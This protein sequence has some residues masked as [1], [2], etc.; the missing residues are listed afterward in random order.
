MLA[1]YA[2]ALIIALAVFLRL[3][4]ILALR[5]TPWFEHLVVD[6]AYYDAWARQ[7]AAGDWFG[8]RPFYMDPLY[9]YLLGV[10]YAVCGH[11]LLAA[12]LVNV[13]LSAIACGALA[14]IGTRV[15]GRYAG[16]IAALGFA[17][18]EPEIFYA[19]EID[20]TTLSVMLTSVALALGLD[21]RRGARVA[22][23]AALGLATLTRA[24]F[25][26]LAPLAAVAIGLDGGRRAPTP[27]GRRAAWLTAVGFLLGFALPL[28]P[29]MWRNHAVGGDWVVT[30]QAGQNFYTGNNALNPYGA[31]GALPFV[32]GNPEFEETD[33]RAEAER[34][35]GHALSPSEVSRFW[36]AA[37]IDHMANDPGFATHALARKLAL[38]W[39]DF[40]IADNQDQYLLEHDSWV[41][42][43]PL[44]GFGMVTALA[45]LG[46]V[47]GWRRRFVQLLVG[48]VAVYCVSVVA[49]F[50]F[51]RY[52][53]QVVPALLALAAVGVL[54]VVA[55]VQAAQWSRLARAMVPT[56]LA[57]WF[58][59]AQLGMFSRSDERFVDLQLHH[60]GDV[61]F[62]AGQPE[63]GLALWRE[64]VE[65]CPLRC[66]QAIDRLATGFINTKRFE[67]GESYLRRFLA[68]HGAPPAGEA[69]LA[70]LMAARQGS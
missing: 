56:A 3:A 31:Y 14:V 26:L 29:V 1:R 27:E 40:E 32:R 61:Y 16:W 50:I 37:A 42:A 28:L 60:A 7:L 25:L 68:E 66:P 10:V 49:F 53:I 12:R 19:A 5:S 41:L 18:Y 4:H 65:R 39:K 38:F 30:T 70:R 47:L 45:V 11:S 35:T 24:N 20:K 15:G 58:T 55:A 6:P 36:F 51:S 57:A 22:A 64:A 43:L 33:F 13:A 46:V 23:G 62:L 63:R 67:Q 59:F 48:L 54:E 2:T 8:T 44:P 52:R 17:L 9:P 21:D 34:Q 69:A